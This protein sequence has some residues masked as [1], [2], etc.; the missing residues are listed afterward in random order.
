MAYQDRETHYVEKSTRNSA[1]WFMAGALVVALIAAG[2]L[3]ANGFFTNDDELS[4]EL[5]V[6]NIGK[7]EIKLPDM[8]QAPLV[9]E[10]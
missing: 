7:S 4:I 1:G 9:K 5:N 10:P 8:K 2:L 6:P 3:Y